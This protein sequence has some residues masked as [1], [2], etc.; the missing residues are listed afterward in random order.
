[1]IEAIIIVSILDTDY[2]R[3]RI[4]DYFRFLITFDYFGLRHHRGRRRGLGRGLQGGGGGGR[5]F[6][7]TGLDLDS[8]QPKKLKGEHL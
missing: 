5:R 2:F 4:P 8:G 7:S 6:H 1:M 3:F